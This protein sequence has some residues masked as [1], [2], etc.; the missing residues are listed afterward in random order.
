M[1]TKIELG[2]AMI[3]MVEPHRE[4]LHEY[5]AWYEGDH[6]YSGVMAG[7]GAFA[8][9]RF[10]ATRDLKALRTPE[11]GPVAD[12]KELGSFIALYWVEQGQL[13]AL[14]GWSFG[15]MPKLVEQGRMHAGRDHVSTACYD[16]AAEHERPG[17][18]PT[19]I[20]LDHPFPGLVVT[21]SDAVDEARLPELVDWFR[22]EGLPAAADTPI[23]A[24]AGWALRQFPGTPS[25][26]PAEPGIGTRLVHTAF[27][28]VDPRECWDDVAGDLAQRLEK[29]GLG[30]LA[31][32]APFVPTVPG[33]D[34]FLDQLW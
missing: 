14:F 34:T 4:T 12:P 30:T 15:E 29:S 7:P 6:C 3:T 31:L 28:T 16:L 1:A 26:V 9:R 19:R 17:G 24:G 22:T 32:A 8:F 23:G 2:H 13:D 10:V 25:T 18:V 27:T 11:H 5:N 21:W 20:A 33:T